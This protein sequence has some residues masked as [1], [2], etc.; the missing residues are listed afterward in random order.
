M[1]AKNSQKTT[2]AWETSVCDLTDV[3]EVIGDE[4]GEGERSG[5]LWIAG[6]PRGPVSC[7]ASYLDTPFPP[8][9]A[10]FLG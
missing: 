8:F 1:P 7:A 6:L 9:L 5:A 4:V 3:R 10:R 2:F